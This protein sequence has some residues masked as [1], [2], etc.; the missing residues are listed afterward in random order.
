MWGAGINYIPVDN[1]PTLNNSGGDTI[2]IWDSLQDYD[3][4]PVTGIGR[5]HDNAIAAVTYDTLAGEGWPTVNNQSS[6]W[7][8]NLA[9]DP[10]VGENW[11]R[12]G[13]AGDTLSRQAGPI[14]QTAIDHP[15]G[16]V[17][18]PGYAPGVVTTLAGDFN[19]DNVVDAADYVVWRKNPVGNGGDPGG[20]NTWRQNLG[21]TNP[22]SGGGA[23]PEPASIAML[24]IGLVAL[25]FRRRSVQAVLGV[26]C[27]VSGVGFLTPETR[28]LFFIPPRSP[29]A[30]HSPTRSAVPPNA[31]A[32]LRNRPAARDR[33][34]G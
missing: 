6:I 24:A 4:E 18:S 3:A 12:S 28:H 25:C 11:T 7:L 13:A 34:A 19:H 2:A 23:V 27:R 29:R 20:Y 31:A 17:G 14:F 30:L 10:N 16:D 1:W 9:G 8:N 32:D 15:G 5:T 21:R 26:R 22:G 33:P